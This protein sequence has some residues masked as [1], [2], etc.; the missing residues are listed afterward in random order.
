MSSGVRAMYR[1]M[2]IAYA[3][4]ES[5]VNLERIYEFLEER[6]EVVADPESEAKCAAETIRPPKK[7]KP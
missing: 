5:R 6:G 4:L 3:L 7:E 2:I 1:T